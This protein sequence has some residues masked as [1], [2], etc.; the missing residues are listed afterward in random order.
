MA[1]SRKPRKRTTKKAA[2]KK[3]IRKHEGINQKTGKLKK[4]YKYGANGRIVK[5]AS[6]SEK[7]HQTGSTHIAEDKKHRAKKPGKRTSANG[8]V[9]Y[10]R[11]ANR[12]DVGK[13]L[14][15]VCVK[16]NADGSTSTYSAA[17]GTD[18]PYGGTIRK[19]TVQSSALNGARK[20][21]PTAKQIA[22]RKKFVAAVRA[23]K[24]RK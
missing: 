24:F 13:L 1:T 21:K 6:A 14:A 18:C 11:R 12:S 19:N 20:K 22:A 2:A 9:Y 10:E 15:P 7:K 23:G 5:V 16:R 8:K 17:H 3:T 4:G